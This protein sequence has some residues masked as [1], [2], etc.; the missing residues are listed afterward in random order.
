MLKE[1]WSKR[2]LVKMSD[3][4]KILFVF[5]IAFPVSIFYR[6]INKNIVLICESA[7]EARDNGYWLYKY[8]RENHRDMNVYY[9]INYDSPDY[10]KV[11]DLGNIINFKSF[12]NWIYFLSASVIASSQKGDNPCPPLF[13]VLRTRGYLKSRFIFLQHGITKDTS[14]WLFYEN[15]KF[16]GFV[17]GAKP[18]YEDIVDKYGY[19]ENFVRYVGFSRFDNLH[20]ININKKQILLM[21]TWREWLNSK[22]EARYKFNEGDIFEESE[23]FKVWNEFL[24]SI[25]L[26]EFLEDKDLNL[27]F[28]P[29][30]NV[31]Q[32]LMKFKKIS[33]NIIFAEWKEYDIQTLLKESAFMITDYSSVF[34][35]F[36][37]MKKPL[38]Y[39]QFDYNKFREGQYAEGYFS[40]ERDGFGP[41]FYKEAGIVEY[42]KESYK[43]KFELTEEYEKKVDTFF[44]LRDEENCFRNY[45]Y[46]KEILN[47]K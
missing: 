27:I 9:S 13:Y 39:Y 21:P 2:K 42:I 7:N 30:R 6:K 31:Q 25:E 37:Y 17:C 19:P 20:G 11:K 12:K 44:P 1:I 32:H 22:T 28:Y 16:D 23:Y 15:T 40:Y 34:M 38:L 36:A 35:D 24:S 5:P 10:N 18:E 4:L 14:T 45:E 8:I 29:H 46:I 26:K 3:I 33:D 41:V 43:N 47:K